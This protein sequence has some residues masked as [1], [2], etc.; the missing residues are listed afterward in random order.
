LDFTDSL[1]PDPNQTTQETTQHEIL[2]NEPEPTPT[3]INSEIPVENSQINSINSFSE[4]NT[5]AQEPLE[6]SS[7]NNATNESLNSL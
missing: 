7:E 1:T 6:V 2:Q 4:G 5:I 3:N